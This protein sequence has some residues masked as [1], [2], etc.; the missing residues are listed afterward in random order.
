MSVLWFHVLVLIASSLG[1][2]SP[3]SMVWHSRVLGTVPLW[4]VRDR[5]LRPAFLAEGWA[6]GE[7]EDSREA[8][9]N[10]HLPASSHN[11]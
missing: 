4:E 5:H 2:F 10:G 9:A 8:G 11:S 7:K 3:S 6:G 1:V